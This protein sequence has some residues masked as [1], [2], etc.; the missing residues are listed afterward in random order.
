MRTTVG[1]ITR[2]IK[3]VGTDEDDTGGHL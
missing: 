2:N 1:H 3:I